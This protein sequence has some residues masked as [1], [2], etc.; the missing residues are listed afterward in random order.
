VRVGVLKPDHLGDLVLA[1][2]AI[3]ALRR[4]FSHLT[5]YCH[6]KNL[7]LAEHLFPRLRA[8]SVHLPHLDKEHG[9]QNASSSRLQRLREEVD[10]LI[11]L[12]WDGQCE[13]L[14]MIPEIEFHT[15]GPGTLIRHVAVEH[16]NLVMPYTGTYDILESYSYPGLPPVV[17]RPANLTSVGLCISAGFRLNA[18][19]VSHWLGLAQL[20]H[21]AGTRSVLIGGPSEVGRLQILASGIQSTLG[22]EPN[23]IV[24]SSD[25]GSFLRQV[26]AQVDLLVATDSG[27]A[28]LAALARPVVSL[29]GGSPWQR[30]APLGRHNVILTRRYPCSPCKQFNRVEMNTCHTQECLT[31]LFPNQV[32]ACLTACLSGVDLTQA[33]ESNGLW[34]TQAPWNA[35]DQKAA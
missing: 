4:R 5:L 6:P 20:L 33:S 2:P 29:F 1:A 3:A 9:K 14:L 17:S 25:F 10:L 11:C 7:G 22:Y 28:H 32:F 12:R 21:Q 15:P 31:N 23:V 13:R 8:R 35:P 16:R 18:W 19:P 30:F 26:A 27:T 24:G 34:M